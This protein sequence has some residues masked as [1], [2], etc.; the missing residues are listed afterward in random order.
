MIGA[1]KEGPTSQYLKTKTKT[2]GGW[3]GGVVVKFVHSA[4]A[5]Q[6]PQVRI[7][8]MRLHTTLQ[9]MLWRHPKYKIEEDWHRG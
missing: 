7:P 6:G 9:A 4:S 1:R 5:T 3:P 2:L 8:G